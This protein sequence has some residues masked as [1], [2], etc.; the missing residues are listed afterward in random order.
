LYFLNYS[1]MIRKRRPNEVE[2]PAVREAMEEL[3]VL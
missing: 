2:G 3:A 1:R